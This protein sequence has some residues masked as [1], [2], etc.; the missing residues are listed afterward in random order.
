M[1]NRRQMLILFKHTKN[2]K[3]PYIAAGAF[4]ARVHTAVSHP[5]SGKK[6]IAV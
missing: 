5:L 2:A 4:N 1:A 3:K 6:V